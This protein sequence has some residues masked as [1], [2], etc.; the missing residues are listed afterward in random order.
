MSSMLLS[1]LTTISLQFG[2]VSH[3]DTSVSSVTQEF[4]KAQEELKKANQVKSLDRLLVQLDAVEEQLLKAK[5]SVGSM[6]V[7]S[8]P[9]SRLQVR[10]MAKLA[11]DQHFLNGLKEDLGLAE[12]D[13]FDIY[14]QLRKLFLKEA[15]QR[16]L[17][18]KMDSQILL[19]VER[20]A[21]E[22]NLNRL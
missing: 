10:L 2:N 13:S 9:L 8:E 16:P 18:K 22:K 11:R 4:A 20:Y 1:A 12:Q 15:E 14:V 5:R 6:E 7:S 17:V 19:A 21:H 3:A